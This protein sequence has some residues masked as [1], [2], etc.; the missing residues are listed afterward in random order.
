LLRGLAWL[1]I[2]LPLLAF[3]LLG[4]AAV[5]IWPLLSTVVFGHTVLPGWP[6]WL[7]AWLKADLTV[8]TTIGIALGLAVYA[9]VLKVFV[10]RF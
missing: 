5:L 9:Q 4:I 7:P 10:T 1:R 3:V 2:G 8:P 6:S